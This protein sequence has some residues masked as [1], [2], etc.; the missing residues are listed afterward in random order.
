MLKLNIGLKRLADKKL[1]KAKDRYVDWKQTY[2]HGLSWWGLLYEPA[3]VFGAL[4][5]LNFLSDKIPN[6]IFWGMVPFWFIFW[7]FVG[8]TDR[9]YLKIW[10]REAEWGARK[11]NPWQQEMMKRVKR[12]ERCLKK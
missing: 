2:N 5:A 8:H 12:I 6:W 3:K 7:T 9:F 4:M 1:D 11:I 10:Q